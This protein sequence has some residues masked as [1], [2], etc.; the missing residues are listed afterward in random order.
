MLTFPRMFQVHFNNPWQF[1]TKHIV[2]NQNTGKTHL[3]ACCKTDVLGT[4]CYAIAL[5]FLPILGA[6]GDLQHSQRINRRV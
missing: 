6:D 2:L 4:L 1:A 5:Y 3:I